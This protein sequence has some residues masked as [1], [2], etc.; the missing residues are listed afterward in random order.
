M[1]SFGPLLRKLRGPVSQPE[2]A[3]RLG[4]S[5]GYLS[6][7]ETGRKVPAEAR[8]HALLCLGF[9]LPPKEATRLLLDVQLADHG[10]R[11]PEL[12]QLVIDLIQKRM[13]SVVRRELR[14][15]YRRYASPK[16]DCPPRLSA[17][18]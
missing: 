4:I 3:R 17:S 6:K 1:K 9:A 18:E 11:D 12:R 10:L 14:Q 2:M 13:P 8:A 5:E 7:L 16:A 15:L